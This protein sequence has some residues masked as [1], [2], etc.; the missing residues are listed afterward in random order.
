[1]EQI[2]ELVCENLTRNLE[3]SIVDA[4]NELGLDTT[5]EQLDSITGIIT[6]ALR[7]AH[8]HRLVI[9]QLESPS[10]HKT[11]GEVFEELKAALECHEEAVADECGCSREDAHITAAVTIAGRTYDLTAHPKDEE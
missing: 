10:G 1:M 2:I 5:Q 8:D 4:V 9:L 11:N 6:H 7:A 3:S